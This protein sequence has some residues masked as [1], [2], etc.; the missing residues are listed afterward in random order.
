MKNKESV[1]QAEPEMC[2]QVDVNLNLS[3][4]VDAKL[5]KAQI[6]SALKK[7]FKELE[8]KPYMDVTD[9][10]IKSV[11]EEAEIYGNDETEA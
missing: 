7:F 6:K 8:I 10:K 5:S 1:K 3:L 2:Q 9:L 4:W 11:K